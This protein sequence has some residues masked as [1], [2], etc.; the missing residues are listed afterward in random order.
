MDDDGHVVVIEQPDGAMRDTPV[1]VARN[2]GAGRVRSHAEISKSAS[3]PVRSGK[4]KKQRVAPPKKKKNVRLEWKRIRRYKTCYGA[5]SDD[6]DIVC[7]MYQKAKYLMELSGQRMVPQQE[8]PPKGMPLW[9]FKSETTAAKGVTFREY[10]CPL[11]FVCDCRVGL[12]IVEGVGYVQLERR[13]L[14]HINSHVDETNYDEPPEL[15]EG[16]DD[17]H[18]DFDT[19]NEEASGDEDEH[20]GDADESVSADVGL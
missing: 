12:R 11:R 13:G 9:R 16:T 17:E 10:E 8:Q 2:G 18:E 14:H 6:E 5:R 4:F 1:R 7:D 15:E 3:A 19:E 20:P